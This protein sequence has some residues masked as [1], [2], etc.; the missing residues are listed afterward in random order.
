MLTMVFDPSIALLQYYV[1]K[2]SWSSVVPDFIHYIS[3]LLELRAIAAKSDSG[4]KGSLHQLVVTMLW[5]TVYL[6]LTL[7]VPI[8]AQEAACYAPNGDLANNETFVPCNKLGVEQAGVFSSCCALDGPL[9][10]RDTCSSSGLCINRQGQPRRGFCTDKSW[11]SKACVHVC[12][13]FE[14]RGIKQR[15]LHNFTADDVWL[16]RAAAM[17]PA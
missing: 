6:S 4:V 8:L 5:H 3:V 15:A 14:V 12:M 16:N 11:K 9:K 2:K 7:V 10:E 1:H 17:S 13:D